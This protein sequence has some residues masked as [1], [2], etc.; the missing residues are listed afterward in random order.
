MRTLGLET[1]YAIRFREEPG[2]AHPGNRTIFS[3]FSDALRLRTGGALNGER[4]ALQGQIFTANGGCFAYE[5]LPT[6]SQRGLLEAGT[7]ECSS[8]LETVLY[9]RAQERLLVEAIP[10]VERRLGCRPGQI[11]LLKNCRDAQGHIYG[12]Q[13]NYDAELARGWRLAAYRILAAATL[14]LLSVFALIQV[15]FGVG[16]VVSL[17]LT[18]STAM[19]V[20]RA[21]LRLLYAW[22]GLPRFLTWLHGARRLWPGIESLLTSGR[23]EVGL[24]YLLDPLM[25]TLL[26]PLTQGLRALAFRPYRSGAETFFV[27]RIP[28]S[29]A[30]TLMEDGRFAL[31]EKGTAATGLT[32]R[33][34]AASERVL[35]DFGNLRKE[36]LTAS[37]QVLV[38]NVDPVRRL[39]RRRQRLQI[40]LSDANRSQLAEYLK[41]GTALIVLEMAESGVLRDAPRLRSPL[42]ALRR[43][44]HDPELSG[45]YAL[46]AKGAAPCT[47]VE[48]QR[49]YWRRARSY[50]ESS[51][52][53]TPE[54]REILRLW[55]EVLDGLDQDPALLQGDLDWVTKQSLLERLP[56]SFSFDARKMADLRYHELGDGPYSDL[57]AAGATPAMFS[58]EEVALAT[59]NPPSHPA[60]RDRSEF[61]AR[62]SGRDAAAAVSWSG[63]W[64]RWKGKR[65]RVLFGGGMARA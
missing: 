43:I 53:M 44:V 47:A 24:Y 52:T 20:L 46:R 27:T 60:A 16:I 22:T 41:L 42:A 19:F 7:P 56:P 31:S 64:V 58:D 18:V 38:A 55:E 34:G 29:G 57:L 61:I 28:L 5:F 13:E 14:F 26:F 10:E 2:F 17:L 9:Q 15:V 65:E 33:N 59:I 25:L 39:F 11:G 30:G 40:G 4:Y 6:A 32:R 50:L 23:L 54:R 49:W 48:L 62:W 36:L 12:T 35:F 45:R 1:E 51:G 8:A 63:G 21:F 37:V 3:A